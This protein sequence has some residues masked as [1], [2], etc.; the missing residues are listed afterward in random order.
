MKLYQ[1]ILIEILLL[2]PFFILALIIDRRKRLT[3]HDKK[4]VILRILIRVII[5]VILM[6]IAIWEAAHEYDF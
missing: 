4:M 1:F 3:K 5:A 2:L 6:F